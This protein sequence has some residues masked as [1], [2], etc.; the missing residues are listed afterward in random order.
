MVLPRD[1]ISLEDFNRTERGLAPRKR[2]VTPRP[3]P[4]P[5]V[6]DDLLKIEDIPNLEITDFSARGRTVR[7]E[8]GMGF[9]GFDVYVQFQ[10]K[11]EFEGWML[12]GEFQELKAR[13]PKERTDLLQKIA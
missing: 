2:K 5:P 11:S 9:T 3:E 7:N 12:E 6:V 1:A 4:I 13:I 10:D 8:E